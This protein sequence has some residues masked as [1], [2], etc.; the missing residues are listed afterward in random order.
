MNTRKD[1]RV[2]LTGGSGF[3]GSHLAKKL[4]GAGHTVR[5]L[6]LRPPAIE[7]ENLE[8]IDGSFFSLDVLDHALKD[9]DVLYHLAATKFPLAAQ[10]DTKADIV[11]N[12]LG[13]YQLFELAHQYGVQRIIFASSGGTVYGEP[14]TVPVEENH[15]TSPISAY[16]ISKLAI[17]KYLA[18]LSRQHGFDYLVLRAANPFGPGQNINQ[19]QGAL[20]TFSIKA[21]KSEKLEIWGDG[22]VERD[23]IYISDLVDAFAIALEDNIESG[24]V[25]IGSGKGTSLN[26]LLVA[27]EQQLGRKLVVEKQAGRN[28]DVARN[29]LGIRAAKDRLNWEPKV[30]LEDGIALTIADMKIR[31]G[32]DQD[33]AE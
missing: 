23:Y 18:S 15:P 33:S 9:V 10:K 28:F 24:V 20:T 17:E 32:Q 25:N 14:E 31:L 26:Q 5:I 1:K 19:A 11:E 16:G 29:F 8:F 4:L 3:I 2:L 6:D 22:T 27:L 12:I 30:S 7:H 21:L 13:S